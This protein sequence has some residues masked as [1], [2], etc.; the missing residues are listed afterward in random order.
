MELQT[1]STHSLCEPVSA[2]YEILICPPGRP[3]PSSISFLASLALYSQAS[4]HSPSLKPPSSPSTGEVQS[5]AGVRVFWKI[6]SVICS[7][8]IAMDS[9]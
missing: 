2:L 7:R 5:E 6:V 1:A 8:L 4:P 9:P 3:P